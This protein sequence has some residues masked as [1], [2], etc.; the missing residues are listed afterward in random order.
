MFQG[1]CIGINLSL[2]TTLIEALLL[3]LYLLLPDVHIKYSA[4]CTA[5]RLRAGSCFVDWSYVHD[6]ILNSLCGDLDTDL[7]TVKIVL[8][9]LFKIKIPDHTEWKNCN[10]LK[11]F[12]KVMVT[13]GSK[14]DNSGDTEILSHNL[15]ISQSLK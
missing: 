7:M 9:T 3:L 6:K 1:V 15:T 5:L 10:I 13:D 2:K 8:N 12:N 11:R 4:N 14:M